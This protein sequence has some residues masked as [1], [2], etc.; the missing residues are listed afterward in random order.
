MLSGPVGGR[1]VNTFRQERGMGMGI[2]CSKLV[3]ISKQK[4][5]RLVSEEEAVFRSA[6]GQRAGSYHGQYNPSHLCAEITRRST[7][8][9]LYGSV[10]FSAYTPQTS[11][12]K[13]G[14]KR[15]WKQYSWRKRVKPG[16]GD[17]CNTSNSKKHV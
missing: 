2:D 4:P 12:I 16:M 6:A 14:E 15:N 1:E 13:D 7:S 17:V 10:T 11:V 9:S 8:S 3:R 5:S